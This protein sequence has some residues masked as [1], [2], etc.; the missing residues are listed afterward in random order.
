MAINPRIVKEMPLGREIARE[1]RPDFNE[2]NGADH[3]SGAHSGL[4]E[5]GGAITEFGVVDR[6]IDQD[7]G[8]DNPGHQRSPARKRDIHSRVVAGAFRR[9]FFAAPRT[10]TGPRAR[11]IGA[12]TIRHSLSEIRSQRICCPGFRDRAFRIEAGMETCPRS[13][14]V[15]A[16]FL[17]VRIYHVDTS[18]QNEGGEHSGHNEDILF[19]G[20]KNQI[21]PLECTLDES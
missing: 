1:D 16:N 5:P 18:C 11:G 15:V 10:E 8:V 12:M 7:A 20:A 17:M 3:Q 6:D 4:Q 2:S 19:V 13:V 14:N 21:T 9:A